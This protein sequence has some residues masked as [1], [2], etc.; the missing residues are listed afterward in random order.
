[1]NKFVT[2]VKIEQLNLL[3]LLAELQSVAGSRMGAVRTKLPERL[4]PSSYISL[5]ILYIAEEVALSF[6]LSLIRK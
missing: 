3:S 6:S 5:A 1:M 2:I 4:S